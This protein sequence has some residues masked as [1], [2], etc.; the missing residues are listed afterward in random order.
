MIFRLATFTDTHR[1]AELAADSFID[2][3]LFSLIYPKRREFY[4]DYLKSWEFRIRKSMVDEGSIVIVA[5]TDPEDEVTLQNNLSAGQKECVKIEKII[6]GFAAWRRYGHSPVSENFANEQGPLR[7]PSLDEEA[8]DQ[9]IEIQQACERKNCIGLYF[10]RWHLKILA[11][12][13]HWWRNGIGEALLEWGQGVARIEDIPVVLEASAMGKK[14][15]LKKGFQ[16]IA[17]EDPLGEFFWMSLMRWTPPG[18]EERHG[19]KVTKKGRKEK[20]NE[21]VEEEG[22]GR[23]NGE[24]K[25]ER[26]EEGKG[27]RRGKIKETGKGKVEV[28]EGF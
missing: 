7:N 5:E 25:G 21:K 6:L 14:L 4:S 2:N 24:R 26:G 1:I 23:G 10:E 22:E 28:N 17:K 18:W 20:D 15:Y 9:I 8:E 13:R 12:D 16:G 27:E 11:V 19:L 3:E